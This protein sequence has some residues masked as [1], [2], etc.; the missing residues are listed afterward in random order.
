MARIITSSAQ[1][2][3]RDELKLDKWLMKTEER[4]RDYF[5]WCDTVLAKLGAKTGDDEPSDEA[6]LCGIRSALMADRTL[7]GYV[8]TRKG[9]FFADDDNWDVLYRAMAAVVYHEYLVAVEKGRW[10]ES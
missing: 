9:D 5:G 1:R 4:R 8:A 3:L 7:E 10:P 6:V 2:R